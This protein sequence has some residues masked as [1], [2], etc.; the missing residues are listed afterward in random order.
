MC[1]RSRLVSEKVILPIL[2]ALLVLATSAHAI[3]RTYQ[4]DFTTQQFNDT[5]ITTARWDTLAGEIKLY[6]FA[7][8]LAGSCGVGGYARQVVVAGNYAY[9]VSSVGGMFVVDIS[10]ASGPVIVG[11]IPPNDTAYDVAI[12]GDHAYIADKN[13]GLQVVDISDPLAP[14]ALSSCPT[15]DEARGVDVAGDY[16]YVAVRN[17]GVQVIDI[18]TPSSPTVVETVATPQTTRGLDIVG[19]YLYVADDDNVVVFDASDPTNLI[20]HDT[21]AYTHDCFAVKVDGDYLFTPDRSYGLHVYDILVPDTLIQV[22]SYSG[23]N[24]VYDVAI[25]GDYAMVAD[26]GFG[27]QMLDISTP[28]NPVLQCNFELPS[29]SAGVAVAGDFVCLAMGAAGFGVV[30]V[31]APLLPRQLIG[32][33]DSPGNACDVTVDGNFAFVADSQQGLRIVDITD[34]ANP[35]EAGYYNSPGTC[36]AVCVSGNTAYIADYNQ[37]IRSV[38]ITDPANPVFLDYL[39]AGYYHD[40]AVDG[41]HVYLAIGTTGMRIFDVT[42]PGNIIAR[43][44]YDSPGTAYG[45]AVN[46][47]HVYIADGERGVYHVWAQ[48]PTSPTLINANSS[49]GGARRVV[50]SGDEVY[51]ANDV[52]TYGLYIL[53]WQSLQEIGKWNSPGTPCDVAVAGDYVFL[54]DGSA[55]LH[56]LDISD[57]ASPILIETFELPGTARGVT[58]AGD[59]VLVATDTAGLQVIRVFQRDYFTVQNLSQSM[60]IHSS[61]IDIGRARITAAQTD[62]IRW[63]LSADGGAHWQD[64]RSGVWCEFDWPG[65]E[66][67]WRASH[68]YLGNKTNPACSQLDIDWFYEAPVIETVAD[69]PNDQGRQVSISWVASAYDYVGSSS[70]VHEYAI[71][72]LI[73]AALEADDAES[74]NPEAEKAA[75]AYP[76]GD[77]HFLKTVPAR[78]EVDYATVVPTLADSTITSGMYH[79]TFFVSALT[80]TPGIYFDSPPDSG[81]SLDNLAPGAPAGLAVAYGQSGN[82]LSWEPPADED[83]QYHKIYRSS[84]PDF[85]PAPENLQHATAGNDWWDAVSEGW[86]YYYLVTAVDFS[87]N[88][89]V[90]GEQGTVT[91][92]LPRDLPSRCMLRPNSPNPFNP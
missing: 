60:P 31:A 30:D 68:Y 24:D 43:G 32:S 83:F 84:T 57:P 36:Q 5:L 7:P 25:D 46:G 92:E 26:S 47:S 3:V 39:A 70:P 19:N 1:L 88:E 17:N 14:A 73:D 28:S 90:P 80:A 62:S 51:V 85:V 67:S 61:A 78:A 29:G 23:L 69:I 34:P 50:V 38:N 77:W 8:T 74:P 91:A 44:L 86:Q 40:V 18:K 76:P 87:G 9:L 89:S 64:T 49:F 63:E 55:G 71:Y 45:V 42:D 53:D 15:V 48:D 59:N 35:L 58:V 2:A 37:G 72:R 52:G 65:T 81:Y 41:D 54:A 79:T 75:R 56:M 33:Y 21:S 10:D 4:E 27:L 66:L 13:A 82:Q 12:S 11:S 6:D 22:G 20:W 16:A